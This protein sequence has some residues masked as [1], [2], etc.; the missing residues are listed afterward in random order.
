M[1]PKWRRSVRVSRLK[2]NIAVC[3]VVR[4]YVLLACH[5]FNPLLQEAC[6]QTYIP[7]HY[8]LRF[9]EDP[10]VKVLAILN[11]IT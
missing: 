2:S 3:V 6:N 11:K 7:N 10:R 8:C 5:V 4:F 9:P 1:R